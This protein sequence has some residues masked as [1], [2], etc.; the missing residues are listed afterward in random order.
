MLSRE[1]LAARRVRMDAQRARAGRIYV[2]A[3]VYAYALEPSAPDAAPER[4]GRAPLGGVGQLAGRRCH[5]QLRLRGA[6]RAA[7]GKPGALGRRSRLGRRARPP[8]SR[9]LGLDWMGMKTLAMLLVA[10]SA[11]LAQNNTL[12]S[13]EKAAGWRLLFDGKSLEGWED[14]GKKS[15]PGMSW[16]V[17]DG[18]LKAAAKPRL[19]E[20]LFT[21]ELFHGLRAG[22][23][24]AHLAGREQR[25]QVPHPGPHLGGRAAGD[26][27]RR[28][29]ERGAGGAARPAAGPRR[30]VRGR[31]RVPG[32]R[33]QQA[34]RTPS[35]GPNTRPG[36]CTT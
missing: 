7:E 8:I 3:L 17:E 6:A 24:L 34:H 5:Y 19:R 32:D 33:R 4:R 25:R 1:K 29:R 15:P 31:V 9:I 28:H 11:C 26:E 21:R 12:T 22:F 27:V 23:R 16:S 30:G 10:A 35:A 2:A 14:P 36:R 20:D 18:C 13:R